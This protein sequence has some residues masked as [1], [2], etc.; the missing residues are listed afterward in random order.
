MSTA[1]TF[2]TGHTPSAGYLSDTTP[3]P[4]GERDPH[5][6]SFYPAGYAEHFA[7]QQIAQFA[8]PP[9]PPTSFTRAPYDVYEQTHGGFA[10]GRSNVAGDSLSHEPP[11]ASSPAPPAATPHRSTASIETAKPS[12]HP[13][14]QSTVPSWT[15]KPDKPLFDLPKALDLGKIQVFRTIFVDRDEIYRIECCASKDCKS[16]YLYFILFY[17]Q[18]CHSIHSHSQ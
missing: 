9:P 17:L 3:Q 8:P 11:A 18:T 4:T 12:R 7:P 1:N 2:T 5:S 14:W 10:R 6:N 13:I 16:T 15:P